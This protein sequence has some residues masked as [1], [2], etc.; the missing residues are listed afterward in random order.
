MS[1]PSLEVDSLTNRM[2]PCFKL[3]FH[4]K[5]SNDY[6]RMTI[7][8]TIE[9]ED[10]RHSENVHGPFW[11]NDECICC[12]MYSEFAPDIFRDATDGSQAIVFAQPSTDSENAAVNEAREECPVQAIQC[13]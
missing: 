2:K 9:L 5:L 10:E 12:D 1:M 6:L 4:I 8:P 13:D 3:I 7:T 11:V